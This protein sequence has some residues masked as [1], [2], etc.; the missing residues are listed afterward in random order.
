ADLHKYGY[1][2]KGASTLF[3]RDEA[4]FRHMRYAFDNWPRG[5]YMTNTLVGTRA[6][7]AIAAAWAVMNYL[8]KE[9]YLRVTQ[10]ILDTRQAFEDGLTGLGMTIWGRP[11]LPIFAWGSESRDIGAIGRALGQRGWLVGYLNEPPGIHLM[12]N[13]THEAV[14]NQYLADVAAVLE[15]IRQAPAAQG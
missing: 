10:R 1:T 11:E 6:G 5:Q 13:M 7:G 14:I 9:G 4:A 8:G 3:F 15:E 2:A 12:L